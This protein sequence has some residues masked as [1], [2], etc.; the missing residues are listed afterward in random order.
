MQ[1]TAERILMPIY[2]IRTPH[3]GQARSIARKESPPGRNFFV[4]DP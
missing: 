1:A 3:Q 4:Y 2:V